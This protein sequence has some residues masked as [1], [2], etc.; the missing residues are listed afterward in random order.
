M[1]VKHRCTLIRTT[2]TAWPARSRTDTYFLTLKPY[3]PSPWDTR[4][5][6]DDKKAGLAEPRAA[7]TGMLLYLTWMQSLLL[8]HPPTGHLARDHAYDK[9]TSGH[10]L[11]TLTRGVS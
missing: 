10:R 1:V 9:A 2:N 3:S 5:D 4:A 7:R 8:H 11:G 6:T